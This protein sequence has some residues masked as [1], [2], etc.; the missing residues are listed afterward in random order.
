MGKLYKKHEENIIKKNEELFFNNKLRENLKN[1]RRMNMNILEIDEKSMFFNKIHNILN[2]PKIGNFNFRNSKIN[3]KLI[4][5]FYDVVMK[6][7]LEE[8]NKKENNDILPSEERNI[9]SQEDKK[10]YK[11]TNFIKKKSLLVKAL[12]NDENEDLKEKSKNLKIKIQK[13]HTITTSTVQDYKKNTININLMNGARRKSRDIDSKPFN[14]QLQK[15]KTI[16]ESKRENIIEENENEN[17]LNSQLSEKKI[18]NEVNSGLNNELLLLKSNKD[19]YKQCLESDIDS[20]NFNLEKE[21]ELILSK[22][23]TCLCSH[24]NFLEKKFIHNSARKFSLISPLILGEKRKSQFFSKFSE[25]ENQNPNTEVKQEERVIY[26]KRKS[27]FTNIGNKLTLIENKPNLNSHPSNASPNLDE[28][29]K[30]PMNGKFKRCTKCNKFIKPVGIYGRSS[31][32]TI[33]T[34]LTEDNY[35]ES[36]DNSI[37]QVSSKNV[38]SSLGSIIDLGKEINM[39]SRMNE[40]AKRRKS[41]LEKKEKIIPFN[42]LQNKTIFPSKRMGT[43]LG[44]F[45][46]ENKN[47]MLKFFIEK[48][49]N[50]VLTNLSLLFS[51]K[52]TISVIFLILTMLFVSPLLDSQTYMHSTL[53][54]YEYLARYLDVFFQDYKY[55]YVK[56]FLKNKLI[57]NN[58]KNK[59]YPNLI[60]IGF[61]NKTVSCQKFASFCE[62][63]PE[64]YFYID[65]TLFQ[66]LRTT[67]KIAFEDTDY[68]TIIYSIESLNKI[69]SVLTIT[70]IIYISFILWLGALMFLKDSNQYVVL[71]LEQISKRIE[72]IQSHAERLLFD[73]KFEI[74]EVEIKSKIETERISNFFKIHTL[75][76]IR[77]FGLKSML[78]IVLI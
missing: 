78:H 76:L 24:D 27:F 69:N 65:D 8:I 35:S 56:W 17:S 2:N 38:V 75:R 32:N 67:S 45:N 64:K 53:I 70:K 55:N 41:F 37:S 71:P 21:S 6:R 51:K 61:K 68:L 22:N 25:E 63:Y 10:D 59:I 11:S 44:N 28:K 29:L 23:E 39:V 1:T 73:Y 52:M 13:K 60:A 31:K 42:H 16:F 40:M 33:Q 15:I 46:E 5:N 47:K 30:S 54:D 9:L 4:E 57:D 77:L 20:D 26:P 66:E 74:E 50:T 34:F 49:E 43:I 12:E 48:K 7:E 62:I 72:N 3:P 58:T 36:L 18:S 19:S 14:I